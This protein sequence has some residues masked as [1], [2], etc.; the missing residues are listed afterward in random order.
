MGA[1]RE[2][3]CGARPLVGAAKR[4]ERQVDQGVAVDDE[5]ARAEQRQ[6]LAR[7]AR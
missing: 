3:D 5:E 4:V 7:S 2:R 6:R 1:D